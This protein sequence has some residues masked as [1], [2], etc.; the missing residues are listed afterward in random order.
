MTRLL[1][2]QA[3][4]HRAF[5]LLG[6]TGRQFAAAKRQRADFYEVAWRE[7][8]DNLGA[9]F[10]TLDQ[11]VLKI[12]KNGESTRVFLNYTELDDPVS[13]RIAGNK[14]LVHKLLQSQ[15]LPTPAYREFTLKTLADAAEFLQQYGTCVVKPAAGTGGG[16]GVTTG[17]QTPRQLR[18]ASVVAAGHGSG[19]MIEQQI[20][21]SNIRLLFLD[22]QLLDAIDRRPPTVTGDGRSTIVQLVDNVNQQRLQAGFSVAQSVLKRDQDMRQTLA[23]QGLTLTSVPLANQTVQLKTVINDNTAE[24]NVC[25]IDSLDTAV[26]DQARSAAE[27]V[28][29]RL[30]GVD[31]VTPDAS[32][33]LTD[34]GGVVLEVNSAPGFYFHYAASNGRT[35]VAI[36]V[37]AACLNHSIHSDAWKTT[38]VASVPSDPCEVASTL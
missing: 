38:Q 33:C 20:A 26:I 36:P 3:L 32:R 10:E 4:A 25:V 5:C 15:G 30:A 12:R 18:K 35:P 34:A 22:G 14:P 8:A 16:Q 21:G 24:D 11:D 13:L 6:K 9:D 31:I 7:A 37:L 1:T 28:G 19:L 2:I 17:V 27:A 23:T 29:L